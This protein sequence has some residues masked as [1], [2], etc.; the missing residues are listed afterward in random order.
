MDNN[1]YRL[2]PE[3]IDE[4]D[5]S[6][7]LPL[8]YQKFDCISSVLPFDNALPIIAN[9]ATTLVPTHDYSILRDYPRI[10]G[11]WYQPEKADIVSID[12]V[13]RV[14]NIKMSIFFPR[15]DHDHRLSQLNMYYLEVMDYESDDKSVSRFLLTKNDYPDLPVYNM[16]K[17]GGPVF[18]EKHETLSGVRE[19]YY[20][21][22]ICTS[23]TGRI[24][25]HEVE[26]MLE[27]DPWP[28]CQISTVTHKPFNA[29]IDVLA[30]HEKKDVE[31]CVKFNTRF[32]AATWEDTLAGLFAWSLR[33][34]LPWL[35]YERLHDN[36]KG[37]VNLTA[38]T[39]PLETIPA[40]RKAVVCSRKLALLSELNAFILKC[41]N[42]KDL[43]DIKKLF[44]SLHECTESCTMMNVKQIDTHRVMPPFLCLLE[45]VIAT[46]R[47]PLRRQIVSTMLPWTVLAFY[48]ADLKIDSCRKMIAYIS[49]IDGICQEF[50][51]DCSYPLKSTQDYNCNLSMDYTEKTSGF[52]SLSSVMDDDA[53]SVQSV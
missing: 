36:I 11:L 12:D 18:I 21:L 22:R 34:H 35:V 24:M 39:S 50:P 9:Q 25:E 23:Y 3:N 44:Q 47:V 15:Y 32:Q 48:F 14:G 5:W 27:D 49:Q 10:R 38:M 4:G 37:S 16:F 6:D 43:L 31:L 1:Q 45:R 26:F 13:S 2:I 53:D 41:Q 20:F 51:S 52:E 33:T 42:E 40:P 46:N 17:P 19:N 30:L 29:P 7:F 28:L 8:Y